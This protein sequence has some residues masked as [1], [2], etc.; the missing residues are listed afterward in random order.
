M[1]FDQRGLFKRNIRYGW[2]RRHYRH[3]YRSLPTCFELQFALPVRTNEGMC[4]Y[5][6]L[7]LVVYLIAQTSESLANTPSFSNCASNC[8]EYGTCNPET[9]RC[10]FG[11]FPGH[12]LGRHVAP[13]K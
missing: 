10:V 13:E 12:Q 8:F 7:A 5:H 1:A 9:H 4:D 6:L 2:L 11:R 3:V